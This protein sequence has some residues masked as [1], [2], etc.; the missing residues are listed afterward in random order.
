MNS[1]RAFSPVRNVYSILWSL[2]LMGTF[3]FREARKNSS[4]DCHTESLL[5]CHSLQ[6]LHT[7]YVEANIVSAPVLSNC[8]N[9]ESVQSSCSDEDCSVNDTCS[10][11]YTSERNVTRLAANCGE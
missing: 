8:W 11:D 4:R 5:A 2:T 10:V 9:V 7:T 6:T 3:S 1:L